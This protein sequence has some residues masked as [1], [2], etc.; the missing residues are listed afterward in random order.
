MTFFIDGQTKFEKANKDS[1]NLVYMMPEEM[2]VNP[3]FQDG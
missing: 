1:H 2:S 3:F